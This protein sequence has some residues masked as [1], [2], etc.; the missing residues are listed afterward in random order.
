MKHL[1]CPPEFK[2][3]WR[4]ITQDEYHA[5]KTAIGSG[6]LRVALDSLRRFKGL[7]TGEIEFEDTPELELGRKVHMAINEQERFKSLM[8]LEP[9]FTGYTKAGKPTT[10]PN[11]LEV[12][13]ARAEWLA[14]LPRDAVVCTGQDIAIITGVAN[15][16]IEHPDA[17][18]AISNTI[19]E[20]AG[21]FRDA[22]TGLRLKIMPDHRRKDNLLFIDLKTTRN[23][24]NRAFNR[25]VY[26]D[27]RVDIQLW[28]YREGIK[29][30]TGKYPKRVLVLA[31]EKK[32]PYEVALYYYEKEHL[33]QAEADYRAALNR[34]RFAIE[35]D[36]WPM[37]Q[38]RVEAAHIPNFFINDSV[39]REEEESGRNTTAE[40]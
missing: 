3:E 32:P 10:N 23:S 21:Y 33:M 38:E 27:R 34:I 39:I 26:G 31:C 24:S 35:N 40:G 22:E 2:A 11:A 20:V 19:P 25:D 12:K 37:R 9:V 29:Q 5:D 6:M 30:I 28:M 36:Y 7:M 1:I 17:S 18:R 15:S 14:S 13:A 8:V 16:I 4:N